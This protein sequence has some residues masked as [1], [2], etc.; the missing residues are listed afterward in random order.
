MFVGFRNS[1]AYL[2][3][4]DPGR[5]I[6]LCFNQVT[7]SWNLKNRGCHARRVCFTHPGSLSSLWWL[8]RNHRRYPSCQAHLLISQPFPFLK[9]W[10]INIK[11]LT[12]MDSYM[13]RFAMA[14]KSKLALKMTWSA[15]YLHKGTRP[16]LPFYLQPRLGLITSSFQIKKATTRPSS[17]WQAQLALRQHYEYEW[18]LS[19]AVWVEPWFS[20]S[21]YSMNQ[22]QGDLM[23]FPDLS[24]PSSTITSIFL[25]LTCCNLAHRPCPFPTSTFFLARNPPYTSCRESNKSIQEI[26]EHKCDKGPRLMTHRALLL[27][28]HPSYS[29]TIRHIYHRFTQKIQTKVP[30]YSIEHKWSFKSDHH[31]AFMVHNFTRWS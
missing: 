17:S 5:Y 1:W 21:F 11:N 31:G 13:P 30:L 20:L 10:G 8:D 6:F 29:S 28:L 9:F 18:A 27:Q 26:L 7:S 4:N 24:C 3:I 12:Q 22:C 14:P 25:V 16:G 23:A 2:F 19:K 15:D